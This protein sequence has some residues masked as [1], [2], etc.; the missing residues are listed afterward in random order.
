VGFAHLLQRI[1]L[2]TLHN[3]ALLPNLYINISPNVVDPLTEWLAGWLAGCTLP[4]T[5]NLLLWLLTLGVSLILSAPPFFSSLVCICHP[6]IPIVSAVL[7][8]SHFASL[9]A[10]KPPHLSWLIFKSYCILHP[11]LHRVKPTSPEV[12]ASSSQ[13]RMGIVNRLQTKPKNA[14]RALCRDM[15]LICWRQVKWIVPRSNL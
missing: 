11:L 9:T 4:A 13:R 10:G 7:C 15:C 1:N 14:S 6:F 2:S 12:S 5:Q 3:T 8:L